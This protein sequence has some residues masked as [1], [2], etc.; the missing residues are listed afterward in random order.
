MKNLSTKTQGLLIVT[1][2][3]LLMSLDPLFIRLS[4]VG[5]WETAFLFGFFTFLSMTII[6]HFKGEGV[7]KAVKGGGWIIFLSALI[8][9]GSGTSIVFSVKHTYVANTMM[10]MSTAP[11]LSAILSLIFL[12]EKTPLRNWAAAL[13]SVGAIYIISRNSLGRA[14]MFGDSMAVL[15]TFFVSSNYVLWRKYKAISRTMV[16]ALGGLAIAGISFFMTDLSSLTYNS[17]IVMMLMGLLTAPIGRVMLALSA[18]YISATEISLFS[19]PR[20]LLATVFI[21]MAY[22]ETPPADT[23]IGGG[24]IIVTLLILFYLT[25]R[26]ESA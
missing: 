1:F 16:I 20:S 9:G 23:F 5:S 12:K 11:I 24:V 4:G 21:W 2:G 3:T 14:N 17:V 8:M 7:V 15:G 19:P 13:I 6:T 22:S 10:I 25:L 18:R 26:Q